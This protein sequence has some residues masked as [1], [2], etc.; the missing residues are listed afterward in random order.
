MLVAECE[1]SLLQAES[2]AAIGYRL[3]LGDTFTLRGKVNSR[4]TIAAQV[5]KR[6]DPLPAQLLLCGQLSHRTDESRFGVGV[7]VG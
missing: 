3:T 4:W 5:E 2:T 6:L 7:S 1:G